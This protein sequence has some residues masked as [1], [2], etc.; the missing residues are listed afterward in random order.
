M[1]T[2][3]TS[4][5]SNSYSRT[6]HQPF[7][8][9][10][11]E[12]GIV[13]DQSPFFSKVLQPKLIIGQ[14]NDKYEQEANK[15]A[16]RVVQRVTDHSISGPS[17]FFNNVLV[18][19]IQA[20]SNSPSQSST[21]IVGE[22]ASPSFGVSSQNT[23][24]KSPKV[25]SEN[26]QQE[27]QHLNNDQHLQQK[28]VALGDD[29]PPSDEGNTGQIQ[30]ANINQIQK[31]SGDLAP[32]DLE[33][34][35]EQSSGKGHSLP[36]DT[37]QE[38]EGAFGADFSAVRIHNDAKAVQMNQQLGAQAF[39]SGGDI[40]FNQGNYHPN[41]SSGKHLLAHELTHTLQQNG[42]VKKTIQKNGDPVSPEEIPSI[43]IL[44]EYVAHHVAY[45][46]NFSGQ[47]QGGEILRRGG[48]DPDH[49]QWLQGRNGLQACL[50]FPLSRGDSNDLRP[51][52]GIRGTETSD[53][54]TIAVDFDIEQVGHSQYFNNRERIQQFLNQIEGQVDIVGH[55][56][57]GAVAQ[58]I[59]SFHGPKLRR[60]VTF[61]SPG[62][63]RTTLERYNRIAE[64]QQPEIIHH[65]AAHDVVDLAGEANL[66]GDIY[67]HQLGND[68]SALEAH[69]AFL[70]GTDSFTA[71]RDELGLT[72]EYITGT[73]NRRVFTS[74]PE[75]QRFEE[76][77]YYI[78][79]VFVEAYRKQIGLRTLRI[80]ML[81]D[82][83]DWI[84]QRQEELTPENS[85]EQQQEGESA[86]EEEGEPL[87]FY[88]GTTWQNMER[89]CRDGIRPLGGGDFAA[90]FYTHHEPDD[91]NRAYRRARTWAT[92]HTRQVNQRYAGIMQLIMA[93]RD[94]ESIR[95]GTGSLDFD[96]RSQRQGNYQERQR[97]WLDFITTYGRQSQPIYNPSSGVWEFPRIDPPNPLDYNLIVG[98]MYRPVQGSPDQEPSRD[99]FRPMRPGKHRFPQQYVWAN[100]GIS[101]LNSG[102]VE[103][104]LEK[105][106]VDDPPRREFGENERCAG[107]GGGGEETDGQGAEE[108]GNEGQIEDIDEGTNSQE[109]SPSR[110]TQDE[111]STQGGG[112][113]APQRGENGQTNQGNSGARQRGGRGNAE[114]F[115]PTTNY[116]P[117]LRPI[118]F[119]V[120]IISGI[121]IDAE[122]GS[123]ATVRIGVGSGYNFVTTVQVRVV[124]NSATRLVLEITQDWYVREKNIGSR[125]GERYTFNKN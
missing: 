117:N 67:E 99:E 91:H 27:E 92:R 58:I 116:P 72:D 93:F 5:S 16:D 78:R 73:L 109:G 23:A 119:D 33:H 61:Q 3:D 40:Y 60:V 84:I 1:K 121:T 13:D 51:I 76:Y 2:N 104:R 9:K 52:L 103:K 85:E 36:E 63:S 48:Y 42:I 120:T 124:E 113:N 38:M 77:P 82:L 65:I 7:F 54:R 90:G 114:E 43:H 107:N 18:S 32:P 94:F 50:I 100:Q 12:T 31:L 19:S 111:G 122:V 6:N 98:P 11:S 87:Y 88:H 45:N 44:Y 49:I 55:S 105:Y 69:N 28:S 68:V 30:L 21:S 14:P 15:M 8:Q 57:G 80:R 22:N 29:A 86:E 110:G 4:H 53:A 41:T 96:L 106:D 17:Y 89:I 108:A 125:A 47:G 112:P 118:V 79:R 101:L 46:R 102:E 37:R 56:L 81:I 123:R 20:S 115:T 35:I 74:N 97:A 62:I 75:I 95:Q 24:L 39:A 59:A 10:K 83:I 70:F 25:D 34:H 64:E 66:P 71:R 26:L